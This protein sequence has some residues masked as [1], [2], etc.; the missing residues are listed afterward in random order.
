MKVSTKG[1]YGLRIMTELAGKYGSGPVLAE[2]I[3]KDQEI[4][5]KYIHNIVGALKTAG[6][7]R[8]SR[9]RNGGYEITR[10]P[11]KITALEVVKVL[12][13]S[14]SPVECVTAAGRCTR[15][16]SCVTRGIWSDVAAAISGV[17]GG[18]TLQELAARQKEMDQRNSMY[19]I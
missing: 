15:A 16:G 4:S 10:D 14:I 5:A 9:G 18:V 17:L 2:T 11:S 13:G 19:S 12:E 6:L 3:A 1:R 8:V 7:V